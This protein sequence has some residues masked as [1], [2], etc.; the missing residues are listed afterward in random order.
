MIIYW[1][2]KFS[3]DDFYKLTL[4]IYHGTLSTAYNFLTNMYE[5]KIIIYQNSFWLKWNY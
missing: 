2:L 4:G 5:L 1:D 3:D